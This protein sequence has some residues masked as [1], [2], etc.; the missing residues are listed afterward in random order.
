MSTVITPDETAFTL[1]SREEAYAAAYRQIALVLRRDEHVWIADERFD[2]AALIWHI[3][4]VR[5]GANG[6]WVLQRH[7][8][9]GQANVLYYLGE[10]ALT[11]EEFRAAR[12][13]GRLLSH[14]A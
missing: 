1:P 4:L 2:E 8:Y 10:R 5:Q 3:D 13:A 12:S 14:Q 6:R 9:D 11:D 7:R